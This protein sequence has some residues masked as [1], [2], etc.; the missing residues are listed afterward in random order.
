MSKRESEKLVTPIYI[1][2]DALNKILIAYLR[3]GE[4]EKSISYTD[5]A[6]TSGVHPANVSR[7]NKFLV[8][9]GFLSMEKRGHFKLT[10]KGS[11]YVR[12]LDWGRLE[13]AKRHL[14][15]IIQECPLFKKALDFISISKEVSRDDLMGRIAMIAEVPPKPQYKVG[16]SAII[17]MLLLSDLVREENGRIVFQEV[18]PLHMPPPPIPEAPPPPPPEAKEAKP[19]IPIGITINVSDVSDIEKLK[20]IIRA[21]KEVLYGPE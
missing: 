11:K 10:E 4:D 9:S 15:E 8:Y 2:L 6:K 20:K 5:V 3:A 12:L 18:K 14:R 16:I 19:P 21:V 17:D 1:G 7:N 13:E